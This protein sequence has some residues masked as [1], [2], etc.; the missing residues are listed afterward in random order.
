MIAMK[1]HGIK[2]FWFWFYMLIFGLNFGFAQLSDFNLDVVATDETCVGNGALDMMVSN[3]EPG[4]SIIYQ[5]FLLP[6]LDNPIAETSVNSFINLQSGDYRVLAI[7]IL[8]GEENS[9]FVDITINDL[10]TELDFDISH[11]SVANCDLT[12]TITVTTM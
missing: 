5:L 4:S 9:Q 12:S 6:D 8:N 3:T 2:A 7:Q 10:T 11:E 1:N